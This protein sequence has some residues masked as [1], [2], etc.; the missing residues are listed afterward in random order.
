MEVFCNYNKIADTM[1]GWYCYKE[2]NPILLKIS[3][4]QKR[5]NISAGLC[6]IGVFQGK[7][8][9]AMSCLFE[10]DEPKIAI[11]SFGENKETD[12]MYGNHSENLKNFTINYTN[13]LNNTDFILIKKNSS[14]IKYT[15]IIS[16]SPSG[17]RIFSI[18]GDH[19]IKGT[20]H[21]LE[22]AKSSICNYGVIVVDD[23]TNSDWPTVKEGVDIFMA[24][25]QDIKILYLGY[26]KLILCKDVDYEELQTCL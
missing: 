1:N 10:K 5:K 26:N 7:S 6:E 25:N 18:D 2:I 22:L 14:D 9:T 13:V 23:Y 19:S 17:V 16:K 11:D 3:E 8:F 20:K 21:D 12:W 24:N 4:F 15:D